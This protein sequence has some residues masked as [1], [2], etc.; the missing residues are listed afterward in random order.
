MSF[1]MAPLG[2]A[3]I[4]TRKA[5]GNDSIRIGVKAA[6]KHPELAK[7]VGGKVARAGL[8]HAEELGQSVVDSSEDVSNVAGKISAGLTTAAG[9][10]TSTGIGAPVAALALSGAGLAGG[11]KAGADAVTEM[12]KEGT[13]GLHQSTGEERAR[14]RKETMAELWK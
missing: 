5:T 11:V 2:L 14:K 6:R 8:K 3:S 7:K 12:K 4:I 10:L 13:L 1:L 9:A